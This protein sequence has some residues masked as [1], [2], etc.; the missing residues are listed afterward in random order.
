[1][2]QT[3]VSKNQVINR[4]KF[5]SSHF[6]FA[7]KITA[8]DG[9]EHSSKTNFS[10][11]FIE[12]ALHKMNCLP[13]GW[14]FWF[15]K[16]SSPECLPITELLLIC[17]SVQERSQTHMI[18]THVC[19]Q[20]LKMVCLDRCSKIPVRQTSSVLTRTCANMRFCASAA[21]AWKHVSIERSFVS[22]SQS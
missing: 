21:H 16:V 13:C 20:S 10:L 3:F 15:S 5:I 4:F 22:C 1:M 2:I 9:S 19:L 12:W 17:M 8:L 14:T 11:V 18:N 6:M 7:S